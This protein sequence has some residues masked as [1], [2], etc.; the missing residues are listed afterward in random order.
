[1]IAELRKFRP[2]FVLLLLLMLPSASMAQLSCE[3]PPAP[4]DDEGLLKNW[5][6]VWNLTDVCKSRPGVFFEIMSGGVGRDGIPPID[7]PQFDDIAAAD[8]WLQPA[9]PVIALEIDG[10]ARAYPLAI[11]TRHEIANDTLNGIPV[12]VTF[13]PL[14]NSAIVF[15][16]RVDGETL[17]FGVSGL[18]RNSDLIMW[19]DK[20]QSLWQQLTGEG[21]IGAHTGALLDILPSQLVGYGAFKEQYPQGEVLAP[22]GRFYGNNPYVNYDSSPRPFLFMGAL[23]DRLLATERVLGGTIEGVAVA[24]PFGELA[25]AGVI[26]DRVGGREVAALWQ[27]G[28]FSALDAA[29]IDQSRDVGMAALYERTVDGQTLSFARVNDAIADAETGSVWNIFGRAVSGELAGQQLRQINAFPH[30]WFAWAAFYPETILYGYQPPS[31][32]ETARYELD[33]ILGDPAAP[34]TLIEY[35]AY[36]CHACKYWHEEGIVE[37]L[38]EEFDGQVNF[39]Y[40]DIPIIVPPYSQ[41]AAE[42]AQC[43]LDQG[44]GSFWT[45]HDVIYR[46][47]EQ[48]RASADDLLRLGGEAGLDEVALRSCYEA[49]THIATVAYDQERGAALGIRST[50]TFVIAGAPV[51][52][53]NPDLLRQLLQAE[54]DKLDGQE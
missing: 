20:T 7:N 3:S 52:N 50:P 4:F 39:V 34:V 53:A 49:G 37:R 43:A 23:D 46:L 29:R 28:A 6:R 54:L 33:P 30:F 18:L 36:G 26:N 40:R 1:M 9:S 51:P 15:D 41:R 44:N 14:C 2:V 13:C 19:D 47:A 17:R 35:G 21:I 8:G 16:R 48:G 42:I 32:E 12:A 31:T 38:L 5:Q 22:G 27:P 25:A 24:Y 10:L 11:L 45:M